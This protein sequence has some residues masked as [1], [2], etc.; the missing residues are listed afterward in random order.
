LLVLRAPIQDAELPHSELALVKRAV[1]DVVS[2]LTHGAHVL[3]TCAAGR[4]RSGLVS[5]LS[6][7]GYARVSPCTAAS[8]IKERRFG[9]D[10]SESLTNPYFLKYLCQR[11]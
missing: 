10:G 9:V 3:V 8:F 11:G 4:N 1:K 5:A 6:L 7:A 2:C